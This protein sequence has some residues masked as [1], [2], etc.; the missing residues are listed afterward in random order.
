[1]PNV[2]L[3]LKN[4]PSLRSVPKKG[5]IKGTKKCKELSDQEKKRADLFPIINQAER[6]VLGHRIISPVW[7]GG[8]S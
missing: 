3:C 5:E 1:M 7:I 2:V 6:G 4:G 8:G